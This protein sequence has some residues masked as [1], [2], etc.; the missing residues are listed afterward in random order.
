ME[1]ESKLTNKIEA[2]LR[3]DT[4]EVKKYNIS[5]VTRS[6]CAT[7]LARRDAEEFSTYGIFDATTATQPKIIVNISKEN[8]EINKQ[9]N[10]W[11]ASKRKLH[12]RNP[13][14]PMGFKNKNGKVCHFI[15]S[16]QLISVI[17]INLMVDYKNEKNPTLEMFMH[18][19]IQGRNLLCHLLVFTYFI[20][21]QIKT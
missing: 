16:A 18:L 13:F 2:A 3:A 1:G 15:S 8:S 7:G 14:W 12:E 11:I 9:I 6:Q 10:E 20:Y 21:R 17:L 5:M 19:Y 4:E